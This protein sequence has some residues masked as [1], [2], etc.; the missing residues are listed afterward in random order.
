[1][2]DVCK[3]L[4]WDSEFFGVRIGRA[5][6]NHVDQRT[7]TE[8]TSWCHD[9]AIDCLYF[10]SVDNDPQ[11]TRLLAKHGFDYVD[12][13]VTLER[14]LP[15]EISPA[16][17]TIGL[18]T[19][20][21]DHLDKLK[22]I[23]ANSYRMSRFYFDGRFVEERCDD[24]YK[25]WVEKSCANSSDHVVVA[26]DGVTP[27]GFFACSVTETHGILG[28]TGVVSTMRGRGI[29]HQMTLAVLQWLWEQDCERVEIVTQGRN[30]ASQ[31]LFQR[32]GF[33]TKSTE[34][35]YHYWP[36]IQ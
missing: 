34:L 14:K 7:M 12:T 8:I 20:T 27:V 3:F 13:R 17:T 1:M 33:I 28:L 21:S 19:C 6:V 11:T 29:G 31:R 4:D 23:A 16:T 15:V 9:N 2:S 26:L 24:L 30:I 10:L 32:F 22:E 5:L 18:S 35:W 25:L 36:N